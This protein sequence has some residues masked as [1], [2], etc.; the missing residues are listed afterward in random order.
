MKGN[1]TNFL[2][3]TVVLLTFG[4]FFY[5]SSSRFPQGMIKEVSDIKM[6]MVTTLGAVL[7]YFYGSSKKKDETPHP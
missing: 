2:A 3:Y 4:Y 6:A 5:I 1:F 7:G